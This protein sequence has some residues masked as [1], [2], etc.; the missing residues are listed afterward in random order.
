MTRNNTNKRPAHLDYNKIKMRGIEDLKKWSEETAEHVV[1]VNN[2]VPESPATPSKPVPEEIDL[3][4]LDSTLPKPVPVL[5]P[6]QPALEMGDK[7]EPVN[8]FKM[9]PPPTKQ[10]QK[11]HQGHPQ[12]V[13]MDLLG[14]DTLSTPAMGMTLTPNPRPT[15]N[16]DFFD[17]NLNL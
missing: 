10:E 5:P 1:V 12:I 9:A 16:L 8:K 13:E 3:L 15:N 17:L 4:G 6:V 11:P 7:A 2:K 14:S